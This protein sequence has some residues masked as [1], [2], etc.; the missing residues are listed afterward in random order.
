MSTLP[1]GRRPLNAKVT[2][3]ALLCLY[4]LGIVL[5]VH[6]MVGLPKGTE[7]G[8]LGDVYPM[9]TGVHF[10]STLTFAILALVQIVPA[11]RRRHAWIH[12]AS[13]RV[14]VLAGLIGAISGAA[15]PLGVPDRPLFWRLLIVGYCALTCVFL[16]LGFAAA[17]RGEIRTHRAWM[18]RAIAA[19]VAVMTERVLF[20]IF[21]LVFGIHD[22]FIFWI[23][24]SSAMTLALIINLGI[25]QWWLRLRPS[26]ASAPA[27]GATPGV[28]AR[29]LTP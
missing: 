26:V 1:L 16:V 14:A 8:P 23:Y 3:G 27:V 7:T 17:V 6:A 29:S 9:W 22:E 4:A 13:G 25:A 10:A 15:I 2:I 24:F 12:R 5:S 21:P 20:P 18:I 19:E 11:I 28:A